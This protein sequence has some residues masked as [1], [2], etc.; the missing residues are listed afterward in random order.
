MECGEEEKIVA[1]LKFCV[2]LDAEE[3]KVYTSGAGCIVIRNDP[4]DGNDRL[5]ENFTYWIDETIGE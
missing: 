1:E 5:E 4:T 3:L 2:Q